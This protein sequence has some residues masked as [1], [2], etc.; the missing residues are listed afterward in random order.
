MDLAL[1][2]LQFANLFLYQTSFKGLVYSI[3]LKLEFA[4]LGKLVHIASPQDRKQESNLGV[5]NSEGPSD[6]ADY[7]DQSQ[8]TSDVTHATG[9]E[10]RTQRPPPHMRPEDVS[11]AMF[12]H[13]AG[14]HD[15]IYESP[16]QEVES[17]DE[18]SST[19][20]GTRTPVNSAPVTQN[21]PQYKSPESLR[22]MDDAR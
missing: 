13:S 15:I 22:S 10:M 9:I 6:T 17:V 16:S 1:I 5:I 7:V 2:A 3:K 11:I 4:V 18:I 12:E 14:D 19:V 8:L 20:S 21:H